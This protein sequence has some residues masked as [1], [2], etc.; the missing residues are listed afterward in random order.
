MKSFALAVATAALMSTAGWSTSASASCGCPP[1][2]HTKAKS[3]A[4]VGNGG[5]PRTGS[6]KE[7]NDR[8]PGRSGAH[9]QAAKNSDKPRSA[10]AQMP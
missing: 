6:Y 5:E 8:D 3:N 4:G 10:A 2:P 1:A 7:W 9:N